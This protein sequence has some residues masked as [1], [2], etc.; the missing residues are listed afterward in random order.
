VHKKGKVL[1]ADPAFLKPFPFIG[2]SSLEKVE[3]RFLS[4]FASPLK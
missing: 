4:Y 3:N 1:A 2:I